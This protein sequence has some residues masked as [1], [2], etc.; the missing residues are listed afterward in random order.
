MQAS[1]LKNNFSNLTSEEFERKFNELVRENS[2]FRN[3]DEKNRK[4]IL[5]ILKK[6]RDRIKSG[7]GIHYDDIQREMYKLYEDRVKLNFSDLD[8]KSA[9]EILEVFKKA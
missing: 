6:Y 1:D 4:V 2:H 3:L 5:E 8:L 7:I 9:K